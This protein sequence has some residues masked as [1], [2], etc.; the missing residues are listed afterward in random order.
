M[1]L[2]VDAIEKIL[3]IRF[4][5]IGDILLASPLLRILRAKFP[6]AEI[7]FLVKKRF[8][9]LVRYNPNITQVLEFDEKRGLRDLRIHKEKIKNLHYDLLVDIHKNFRSAYVRYGAGARYVAKY[10]KM[11]LPRL[12]LI[13]TKLNMYPRLMPVYKRY[14]LSVADFG[15]QDDNQGLEIFFPDEYHAIAHKKLLENGFQ[16]KKL[17]IG[18]APGAGYFT[19]RW[20]P[21]YYAELADKLAEDF[22]AEILLFGDRNDLC[23]TRNITHQMNTP[24]IDMAGKLSILET[25]AALDKCDALVCNDTGLMH[26]GCAL[27]K[28]VVAVFGPTTEELGF[29]PV[30]ENTQVVQTNISCRPCSHVGSKHCPRGHFKCMKEITPNMVFEEIRKMIK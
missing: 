29:F 13:I 3:V 26:I 30:G 16:N 23:I 19:K 22:D 8:A 14:L 5:S 11:R 27:K 28:N 24:A 1:T 6:N 20:L 7:D 10:S 12:V 25:A 9:D 2:S 17:K 15:M 21:D 4:S 18:L